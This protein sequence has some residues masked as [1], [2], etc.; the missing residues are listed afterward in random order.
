VSAI[1]HRRYVHA[2]DAGDF[3]MAYGSAF[4]VGIAVMLAIVGLVMVWHL[5]RM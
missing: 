5:A 1:R 4:A 2:I 3:R